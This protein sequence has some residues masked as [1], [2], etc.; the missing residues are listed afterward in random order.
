MGA[1]T[2]VSQ[3]HYLFE[4]HG[5][6]EQN[7]FLHA[8]NCTGQNKNNCMIQYLL[9]RA[10]TGR[11][12]TSQCH[13]LWWGTLSFLQTGALDYSNICTRGQRLA[14]LTCCFPLYAGGRSDNL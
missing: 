3:L 12:L 1:N 4:T 11:Q 6:G 8:D 9:W 14:A 10:M 13:S 7:V 5:M 2:V